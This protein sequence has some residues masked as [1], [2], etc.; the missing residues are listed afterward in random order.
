MFNRALTSTASGT[1]AADETDVSP[2]AG[3]AKLGQVATENGRELEQ[4][5]TGLQNDMQV[6]DGKRSDGEKSREHA[7]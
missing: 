2:D 4:L 3:A 7:L 6:I 1:P 5:G